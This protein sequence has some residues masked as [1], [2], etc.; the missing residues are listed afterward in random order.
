MDDRIE[1]IVINNLGLV[2]DRLKK[3]NLK[4]HDAE[5]MFNVGVIGLIKAA[6][7]YD[8]DKNTKFATFACRCIDNEFYMEFRR[9]KKHKD[10]TSLETP[11]KEQDGSNLLLEDTIQDSKVH[12]EDDTEINENIEIVMDIVLNYL[13]Q[14]N[15]YIVLLAAAGYTQ[16]MIS[17]EL[18]YSQSYVSRLITQNCNKIKNIMNSKSYVKNTKKYKV[19]LKN[20]RMMIIF[21]GVQDEVEKEICDI[22]FPGYIP[23]FEISCNM[24]KVTISVPADTDSMCFIAKVVQKLDKKS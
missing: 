13:E 16:K 2:G 6:K 21:D 8:K 14:P 15:R 18:N 17:Q 5:E 24:K 22:D 19:E 11:I 1:E 7:R 23:M 4:F 12:I 10:V 9:R 3:L 20:Q